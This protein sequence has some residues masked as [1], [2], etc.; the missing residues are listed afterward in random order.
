LAEQ[1]LK[2]GPL[3]KYKIPATIIIITDKAPTNP[4]TAGIMPL[5][6]R[7][8]KLSYAKGFLIVTVS[9]ETKF[10]ADKRPIIENKIMV[11]LFIKFII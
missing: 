9:A 2:L 4:A 7:S 8:L 1:K 10:A 11:F 5:S 3:V 6:K